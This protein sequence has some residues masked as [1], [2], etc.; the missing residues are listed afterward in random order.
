MSYF[1]IAVKLKRLKYGGI[2]LLVVLFH[3]YMVSDSA[4]LSCSTIFGSALQNTSNSGHIVIGWNG[5]VLN[6]PDNRLESAYAITYNSYG[7]E[8]CGDV[9]CIETGVPA[10][11][12]TLPSF[13]TATEPKVDVN[14]P[15]AAGTGAYT[16]SAQSYGVLR[17][18]G[19]GTTITDA[20]DHT[21]YYIDELILDYQDSLVLR[22]GS[23]YWV[24]SL[25]SATQVEIRVEG[26][27]TARLYIQSA[28]TFPWNMSIN[29]GG[30]VE[31]LLIVAYND[32][33]YEIQNVDTQFLLY[34]AGNV[35]L[36]NNSH[37]NGA[38]AADNDIVLLSSNSVV[39]YSP[40]GVDNLDGGSFCEAEP[41][42]QCFNDDFNRTDLESNWA[43]SNSLGSF[44]NPRIVNGRLRMT[45]SSNSVSTAASLL[46][47]FPGAGNKMVYEFDHYAYGGS[48]ADG[49]AVVFSDAAI[50][51]IPGGYGGSLGYAQRCGI[52]GFAGG[53]LG[54]GI[55]EFGNFRNDGECRGDGG[56]PSARV[57]DSVA[58]RG[59]GSGQTGYLLHGESGAL[60]P[61]IDDSGS[62][63]P[64]YGHHYRVTIDH[65]DNLHA[66]VSVE[67]DVG[68]GYETIIPVYDAL[69]QAGQAA[70]PENWLIS[71]TGSTGGSRNIHEIDNLQV[72]ATSMLPYNSIHHYRFYHDGSALTCSPENI[73]VRACLD[74]DCTVEFAGNVQAT[75]SPSE[76]VGGNAQT[77]LSGDILQLWHTSAETATLGIVGDR[78]EFLAENLPRCFVGATEQSD[79]SLEFHDSG[80]IFDVPD[81]IADI[82]QTVT[83]SA[84]RKDLT[85]EQCVPGFQDVSKNVSF[86]SEYLNPESGSYQIEI[87]NI[88]MTLPSPGTSYSLFFDSNG[89]AEIEVSYADVGEMS[90]NAYYLGS[91]DDAGL[92]MTGVDS[93]ITRPDHFQVTVPGNPG[94][95][96]AVG[97][98][99]T[100]AGEI[101]SVEVSARNASG[102]VTPNYGQE[103]VAESVQLAQNLEAP[104]GQHNPPL[105][106]SFD[107][108][109]TN[110]EGE[111]AHGYVCGKFSWNEAGIITVLPSVADGSYLGSGNTSG[112]L[113]GFIGRF[114][115]DRFAVSANIP[116]LGHGCNAGNYT[117]LG[118][119]F[120]FLV[121]PV[122]TVTALGIN[123]GT[124]LNYGGD[125]WRY[126]ALLSSRDYSH[127]GTEL[128]TVNLS[129]T[130]TSSLSGTT[131]YD[132][133][134]TVQISG[135]QLTYSKPI[136]A[137]EP[138][139]T[140]VDLS[141]LSSDL[142]DADGVCYEPDN[143]GVCHSYTLG[144]ILGGEQRYG[145][146]RLQNAYGP[147]TLPLAV[148]V[149]T[150]Y[151][152]GSSFVLNT[153]DSCTPYHA[154]MLLPVSP[155]S[156]GAGETS[157]TG[158][159]TLVFGSG[160][161]LSL[162][163][164]GD[165]NGGSIDLEYDLDAAGLEWLKIGSDN[166]TAEVTFG[167]FKG[168]SHLIYMRES[169][170]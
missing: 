74:A 78:A 77:F 110:C 117:Y 70:V 133:S 23:S 51:P 164:P 18:N 167:I 168:N 62:S 13:L 41:E 150:E 44:G 157:A 36:T 123:G 8:T 17:S 57:L 155:I 118:Q 162:S 90:L 163:A 65:E 100:T 144:A 94:A 24:G 107:L 134:G 37:F 79:C 27:G 84:V 103:A 126:S 97:G 91:G 93:F 146:M 138:F 152:D 55:D 139:T 141:L 85:S 86:W 12:V 109:G 47:L 42:L 54:L 61:P 56:S 136:A 140:R 148:P 165:G 76:W 111:I 120:G 59:S 149:V 161:G 154:T 125:F 160:S 99:F 106:G 143:D 166:P 156:I 29:T 88:P 7:L 34:S 115:P 72:C 45:D 96:S 153:A 135:D 145:Q 95:T 89:V 38:I 98:I 147:E 40:S 6:D 71:M 16:L 108:F 28:V 4:G 92:V 80:F 1:S 5:Q 105:V 33:Q 63:T 112:S 58:V 43:V 83:L 81:H 124:L 122:L 14:I 15:Y 158:G 48:G 102:N 151:F 142:Q 132:G 49:M 87:N 170:W 53:W 66:Y 130:G 39:S 82:T 119:E 169:V 21:T 73:R 67:R 46:R 26:S 114:I 64:E 30:S 32:V 68:S 3:L 137:V 60:T 131:D 159:G 10:D 2:L 22:G 116:Q 127:S 101:F 75:L 128:F 50:T 69:V 104:D 35:S 129:T 121:D 113:S 25:S 20:G 31:N 19:N 52:S 11:A 9:D